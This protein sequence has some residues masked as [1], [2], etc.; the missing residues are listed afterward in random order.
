[1]TVPVTFNSLIPA[2]IPIWPGAGPANLKRLTVTGRPQ[3]GQP[4]CRTARDS[5]AVPATGPTGSLQAGRR[6]SGGTVT[7]VPPRTGSA[8]AARTS[9]TASRRRLLLV[10]QP[11]E[12]EKS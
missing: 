11:P 12:S 6:G 10:C 7:A 5:E 2:E 9:G 8:S 3:P 4:G 1:M